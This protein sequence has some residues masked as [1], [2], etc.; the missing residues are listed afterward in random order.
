M[1]ESS[2][3]DLLSTLKKKTNSKDQLVVRKLL[4]S[5]VRPNFL[6][7]VD[8]KA[9]EILRMYEEQYDLVVH[10]NLETPS[11]HLKRYLRPFQNFPKRDYCRPCHDHDRFVY[12]WERSRKS[13]IT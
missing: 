12:L 11:Y 3:F 8:G 13:G 4:T 5:E 2:V 1:R 9:M 10:G 7:M 6:Q